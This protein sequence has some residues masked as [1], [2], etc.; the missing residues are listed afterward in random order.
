MFNISC[1]TQIFFLSF[2]PPAGKII[3]YHA[4]KDPKNEILLNTSYEDKNF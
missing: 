4:Q 1:D 2:S 3:G